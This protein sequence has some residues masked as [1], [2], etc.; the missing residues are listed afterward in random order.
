M[1]ALA[2]NSVRIFLAL[3]LALGFGLGSAGL[4]QA[5]SGDDVTWTVRTASNAFGAE[6]TSYNYTVNPGA[7]IEDAIVIA[8]RGGAALDLGVYAA[9]GYT[10]ESGQFDLVV[11]GATSVGI[12]VWVKDSTES[13]TVGPGQTVEIPFTLT[14]P[15]NAT[16]GDYAGGIVTSLVQPG[17]TN[18]IN[19]DRRLGIRIA[20]RV[21][22]DLRPSLAIEGQRV[23]WSGG[24]NPFAGGDA[25]MSYTI[26]NTGNAVLSAQQT[27]AV[28]GPFGWL[29]SEAG[30]IEAPPQLLPGESWKVTVPV[31]GV[32]AAV[33]L[34]A[35]T[36]VTPVVIDASGSMTNLAPIVSTANGWAVPW[37]LLAI[38]AALVALV[39]LTPR[40]RKRR[41]M[42][43]Q[44]RED[45]R[46]REAIEKALGATPTAS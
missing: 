26:H 8:N 45:A 32:A 41:R 29:R 25:T 35:T 11:G 38:V 20:L 24:L 37:T 36:T 27:A 17:D 34:A 19:V 23:D 39:I 4:A 31:H 46:V 22:G 5:A 10:T 7:K 44:A 13:V 40:L 33:W 42:Q 21:G 2:S 12:G 15:Q 14:V 16:P 1:K 43:Q 9:D 30:A 3:L 18:G 6:R 28:T